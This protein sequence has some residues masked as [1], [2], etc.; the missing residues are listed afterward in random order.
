MDHGSNLLPLLELRP[1]NGALKCVADLSQPSKTSHYGA[2]DQP[3][4]GLIGVKSDHD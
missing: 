3:M 2:Y 4:K 1:T